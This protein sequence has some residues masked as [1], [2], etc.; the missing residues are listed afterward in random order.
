MDKAI[1]ILIGVGIFTIFTCWVMI[2]M[3]RVIPFVE[4][5]FRRHPKSAKE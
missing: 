5:L 4:N 3:N 1:L 2:Y